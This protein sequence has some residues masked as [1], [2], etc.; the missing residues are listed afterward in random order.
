M[1]FGRDGSELELSILSLQNRA[2]ETALK[3]ILK[4]SK[5][6]KIKQMAREALARSKEITENLGNR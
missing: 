1:A 4:A 3:S 5:E 2:L 6:T